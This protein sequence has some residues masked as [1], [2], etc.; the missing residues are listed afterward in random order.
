MRQNLA[1]DLVL[2]IVGTAC[3]SDETLDGAINM[4][5]HMASM[6]R[7]IILNADLGGDNEQR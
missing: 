3:I 4:N 5:S 6:N 1:L 7:A 2:L